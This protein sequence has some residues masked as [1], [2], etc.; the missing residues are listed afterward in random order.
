MLLDERA[1]F[2]V[3]NDGPPR[4]KQRTRTLTRSPLLMRH[5]ASLYD[6]IN[7]RARD[8]ITPLARE[9]A[10]LRQTF[11]DQKNAKKPVGLSVGRTT[12]KGATR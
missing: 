8:K 12:M 3:G 9:V 10:R 6:R 5:R 2:T 1:R 11:I 7:R 4:A